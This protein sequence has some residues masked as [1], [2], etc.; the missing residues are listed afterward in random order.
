MRRTLL[1]E[2]IKFTKKDRVRAHMPGHNGGEGLSR[3]FR[4]YAFSVDVTEFSETDNLQQPTGVLLKSEQRAAEI[5]GAVRTFFMVGGSTSGLEAAIL[6]VVGQGQKVIVDRTCHKAV[7][8]AL[9]LAGAEPVFVEPEFD[10]E[11]GIYLNL[12]PESVVKALKKH[13]D[14]A[15]VILTSPSYMGVCSDIRAIAE[16]VHLAGIPLIVDEAHGAHFVFSD[17]L[18]ET[19][20]SQ[21]ADIVVQSTHKTLAALGQTA[22][23]HIGRGGRIDEERL[24]KNINLIQTSSPS[25]ML[26]ASLDEA[27]RRMDSERLDSVIDKIVEIKS[28]ISVIDNVSCILKRDLNTDCDMT[29]LVVDFSKLGIT[30]YGAAKL[31]SRDYG[32]YTEMADEKN[33]L[34]YLTAAATD[35]D[36]NA[37][38]KAICEIAASEFRPQ[39]IIDMRPMPE[40]VLSEN[41]RNS[42]FGKS[43]SVSLKNAVGRIAAETLV[44][45][46]PCSPITVPGQLIDE[47]TADYIR[48]FTD[49]KKIAVTA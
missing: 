10:F 34:F 13:S 28:R 43:V 16:A 41:M 39:D 19:A 37:I 17:K 35:K 4:R 32:I 33:V 36:L 46:P 26:L 45:C 7:V 49:I 12:S 15:A 25:Y 9:I 21:D 47:N 11:R 38:D 29:K 8:S 18:P 48:D 22:L 44:C 27:V 23:L 14:A 24:L 31:L 3:K 5:F 20:L 40:I 6:T 42:Y 30:G 2:L 1:D